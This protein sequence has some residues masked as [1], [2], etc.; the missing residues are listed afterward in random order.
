MLWLDEEM[1][2]I[3]PEGPV[4]P[5]TLAGALS[6]G[7]GGAVRVAGLASAAILLTFGDGRSAHC[8]SCRCSSALATLATAIWIGHRLDGRP[9]ARPTLAFLCA[10]GQ[11]L[12]VSRAS[13]SNTTPGPTPASGLLLPA[14]AVWALESPDDGR[15]LDACEGLVDPRGGRASGSPNGRASSVNS[16]SA[17]SFWC[18]ASRSAAGP[19]RLR[20]SA[21]S[22]RCDLA[23]SRSS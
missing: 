20:F 18:S 4:D 10:I 11:W 14:L 1:I 7:A 12:A 23:S 22:L 9:P 6:L 13:S 19:R 8:G 5:P 2:A 17:R 16:F 3:K 15:A 21:A